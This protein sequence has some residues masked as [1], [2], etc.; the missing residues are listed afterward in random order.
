MQAA[1][2]WARDVT[3]SE[4]NRRNGRPFIGAARLGEREVAEHFPEPVYGMPEKKTETDYPRMA[5]RAAGR[6]LNCL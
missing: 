3:G 2:H 5:R 1:G 6:L 4:Q